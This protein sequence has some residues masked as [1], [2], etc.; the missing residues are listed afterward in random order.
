MV[1]TMIMEE[2]IVMENILP[3]QSF[4]FINFLYL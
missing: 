3:V 2:T 1:E 4:E